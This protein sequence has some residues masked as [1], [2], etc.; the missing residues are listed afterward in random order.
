VTV[1]E[2]D[3]R[4]LL[5]KSDERSSWSV[6]TQTG[7]DLWAVNNAKKLIRFRF[8]LSFYVPKGRAFDAPE[9]LFVHLRSFGMQ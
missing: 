2:I 9:A 3:K 4:F 1:N 6:I 5:P 7:H 8:S